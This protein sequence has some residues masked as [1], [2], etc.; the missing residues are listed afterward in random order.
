MHLIKYIC[1]GT[2]FILKGCFLVRG[3]SG[4]QLML[5]EQLLCSEHGQGAGCAAINK[6]GHAC[7]QGTLFPVAKR[8]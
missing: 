2:A 8:Q 3:L 4:S 5:I 1:K 7:L 6:T